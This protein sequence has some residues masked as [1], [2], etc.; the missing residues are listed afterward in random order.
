VVIWLRREGVS[1]DA[2]DSLRTLATAVE[3]SRYSSEH[4]GVA[5][6]EL[7]TDLRRVEVSLRETRSGW[8]RVR[9]RLLPESLGWRRR[10]RRH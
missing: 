6:R 10:R 3:L 1:G 4:G 8:E 5:T 7:V 9:A 2:D